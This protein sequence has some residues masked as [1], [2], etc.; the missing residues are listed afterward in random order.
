MKSVIKSAKTVDEAVELGLRDL[1]LTRDSVDIE[2]LEESKSGF[3]GIFGSKDAIVKITEKIDFKIDIN[4]IYGEK[5][6]DKVETTKEK[7]YTQE[8]K[9]SEI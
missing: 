5:V 2:V 8:K 9:V 4:D 1:G 3:L 6:E 7:P